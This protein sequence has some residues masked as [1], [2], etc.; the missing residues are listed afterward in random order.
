MKRVL[1]LALAFA[2]MISA[3]DAHHRTGHNPPGHLKHGKGAVAH[4]NMVTEREITRWVWSDEIVI[5]VAGDGSAHNEDALAGS[6]LADMDWRIYRDTVFDFS[7]ELPFA[8]F[9]PGLE[10]GRGLR[11]DQIG[12]GQA[13]LDVYGA[14]NAQGLSPE[15]FVTMLNE[16]DLIGK[17]TYRAGGENWFV[18]SGYYA[19]SSPTGEQMIFYTKFMF[20][21]D[22][23]RISAFEIGYPSA[24]RA[25]FDPIV[26]RLEETLSAP[27]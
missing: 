10:G 5:G 22:G 21:D 6:E 20:S 7:I 27:T 14:E 26:V 1:A 25:F 24:D 2:S 12:G 23:K 9:E 16:G 8:V 17:V 4:R 3:A 15:E 18:L 19:P 13:H 11:L